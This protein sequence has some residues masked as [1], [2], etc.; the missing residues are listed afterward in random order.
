MFDTALSIFCE[1]APWLLLGAGVAGVL[2]V[3][4]PDNW[5]R[6]HLSGRAG[7][8]K[9]VLIG[10][11]LP[12][13][14]CGVIPVGLSLRK[15]GA[16]KGASVG[17]LISTPQTGVDSV[18]VSAT[19]LGWPFALFKVVAALVTGL[20][21]GYLTDAVVE[22]TSEPLP[23]AEESQA[24]HSNRWRAC[25][26]HMVN[27]IQSI[28]FWLLVG[29]AVSTLITHWMPE[30]TL[31]ETASFAGLSGMLITL[32]ISLP[33]YV[34]ATAS[35]PIAAALVANGLPAGSAL[36]FLMAGPATNLATLGAVYRMLGGKCLMVYLSTIIA[37]SLIAAFL[38]D[39]LIQTGT[40][41][42][43][44]HQHDTAWW[45]IGSAAVLGLMIAWMIADDFRCGLR[46]YNLKKQD[47]SLTVFSVQGM[48]CDGCAAKL[49]RYLCAMDD[50]AAASFSYREK[51]ATIKS[52]LSE[53]ELCVR[54]NQSGFTA[55]S[56]E[57]LDKEPRS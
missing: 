17:F 28:Y 5:F 25:W 19:F 38:F 57:T 8:L 54:I 4:V 43:P 3:V 13:C 56:Q 29:V 51:K 27:L 2:H 55:D 48:T 24:A 41:I 1:L 49:E 33:L 20:A 50:I 42:A 47:A 53:P 45:Q 36:V 6:Q 15:D 22:P 9:S 18:L 12:L 52:D 11:P 46:R 40:V 26:D 39:R 10:V 14:S 35:V 32:A 23:E 7:V 16:S 37:G 31:A 34:C 21:G 44:L 30:N